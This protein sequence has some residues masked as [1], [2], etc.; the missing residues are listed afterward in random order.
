MSLFGDACQDELDARKKLLAVIVLPQLRRHLPHERVR[1]RIELRPPCGDGAEERCPIRV[2][3][4]E[5][6]AR[7]VLRGEAEDEAHECGRGVEL[8]VYGDAERPNLRAD[9]F[10][11]AQDRILPWVTGEL[12]PHPG[13]GVDGIEHPEGEGSDRVLRPRPA[14][15]FSHD[16]GDDVVRGRREQLVLVGDV[17]VDSPASSRQTRRERTE[18]QSILAIVVE[19]V[20]RGLDDPI[21]RQ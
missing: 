14:H 11:Y 15:R 3:G 9:T 12:P 1:C 20:Y 10:E 13:M 19:D 21:L 18:G 7:R 17:P 6:G 4:K 2:A 5:A 8:R 16:A